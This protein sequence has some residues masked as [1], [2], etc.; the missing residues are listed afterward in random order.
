MAHDEVRS[1]RDWRRLRGYGQRELARMAEISHSTLVGLEQGRHRG[2]PATW[3]KI[4]AALGVEL[5]AI[6]EYR[7]AVGLD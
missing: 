3:R 6:A 7:R 2:H 5:L 4:A 1:L